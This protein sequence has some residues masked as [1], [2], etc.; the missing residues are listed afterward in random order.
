M[1]DWAAAISG[2][3]AASMP[4]TEASARKLRRELV[5]VLSSIA[6][7]S[8]FREPPAARLIHETE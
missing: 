3:K 4:K 1:A 6:C 7:R 5:I 8:F 2:R